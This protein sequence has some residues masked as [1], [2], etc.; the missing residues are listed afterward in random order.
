VISQVNNEEHT[1]HIGDWFC[2]HHQRFGTTCNAAAHC[3][4]SHVHPN[5]LVSWSLCQVTKEQCLFLD[6]L[7]NEKTQQFSL[8]EGPPGCQLTTLRRKYVV[9]STP[10]WQDKNVCATGSSKGE[11]QELMYRGKLYGRNSTPQ[12]GSK[13]VCSTASIQRDLNR[14]QRSNSKWEDLVG[15]ANVPYLRKA[16]NRVSRL[17]NET[18]IKNCA[19]PDFMNTCCSDQWKMTLT[20]KSL[21]N[22]AYHATA[23]SYT[24][25]QWTEK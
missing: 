7:V 16:S 17:T 12:R 9:F 22:T 6:I 2:F 19:D 15:V 3:T 25:V 8:T 18:Q 5:S 11:I 1:K 13:N 23:A 24:F 20:L 21:V 4:K 10:T 14:R